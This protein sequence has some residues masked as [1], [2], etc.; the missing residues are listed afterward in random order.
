MKMEQYPNLTFASIKEETYLPLRIDCLIIIIPKVILHW[1]TQPSKLQTWLFLHYKTSFTAYLQCTGQFF[2]TA[3]PQTYSG[4]IHFATS[5]KNWQNI[6][7]YQAQIQSYQLQI[8]VCS[9][10][11]MNVM[12]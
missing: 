3:L 1:N 11:I 6:C 10:F 8:Y 7:M 4:I 9:K 2:A 12:K 5:N